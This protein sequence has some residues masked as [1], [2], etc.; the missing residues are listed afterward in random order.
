MNSTSTATS[1]PELTVLKGG[2]FGF[3]VVVAVGNKSFPTNLL[4][5]SPALC[6]P[7]LQNSISNAELASSPMSQASCEKVIFSYACANDAT[8]AFFSATNLSGTTSSGLDTTSTSEYLPRRFRF[9][10]VKPVASLVIPLANV[11]CITELPA[12][13]AMVEFSS[14]S[15]P[16]NTSSECPVLSNCVGAYIGFGEGGWIS[17]GSCSISKYRAGMSSLSRTGFD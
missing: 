9:G 5:V 17:V 1:S 13:E 7:L 16:E 8:L 6:M 14:L 3:V 10:S 12:S 11:D 4:I 2:C 15:P